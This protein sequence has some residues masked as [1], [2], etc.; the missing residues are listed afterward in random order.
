MPFYLNLTTT[1]N[2]LLL[3]ERDSYSLISWLNGCMEKYPSTI[4]KWITSTFF[5]NL[6]LKYQHWFYKALYYCYL[7]ECEMIKKKLYNVSLIAFEKDK[8]DIESE[9]L[10]QLFNPEN[11]IIDLL[12]M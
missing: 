12:K 2:I 10:S 5:I 3:S 8:N 1:S 4:H 6:E 9:L 7:P 11:I